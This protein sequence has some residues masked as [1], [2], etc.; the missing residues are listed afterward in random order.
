[1]DGNGTRLPISCVRQVHLTSSTKS[2]SLNNVLYVPTVRLIIRVF[3]NCTVN[4][5]DSFALIKDKTTGI[6][7]LEAVN[8]HGI[9]TIW[10]TLHHSF[11]ILKAS[12]DN[13]HSRPGHCRSKILSYSKSKNFICL[14][15]KV[16]YRCASRKLGEAH[17]LPFLT[18][19]IVIVYVL[20]FDTFRTLVTTYFIKPWF[21]YYVCYVNNCTHCTWLYPMKTKIQ[22]V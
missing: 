19:S 16:G 21:S 8:G 2:L 1:M 20:H 22:S 10:L 3:V 5:D 4:F 6:T 17:R 12:S 7:L 14:K 11:A 13:L 15:S 9:Y 18:W